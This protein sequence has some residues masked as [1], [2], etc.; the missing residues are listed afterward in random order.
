MMPGLSFI[1]DID[2]DLREKEAEILHSLNLLLHFDHYKA[3]I[4]LKD[5]SYFLCTTTYAE[6]PVSSFENDNYLIYLEG[7]IY[8][9]HYS[10]KKELN[11]LAELITENMTYKKEKIAEWLLNNDGDFVIFVLH[12]RSNEITITNDALGRLPLYYSVSDRN[13]LISREIR[14][15][16]HLLSN[17]DF[18]RMAI[19]QYLLFGYPLGKRTL[20]KNIYR[21]EPSSLI[22]INLNNSEIVITNIHQFCFDE[23]SYSTRTLK[24]NAHAL[25]DLFSDACKNRA[26]SFNDYKH[27]LSLSGGL[28]SRSVA[29]GLYRSNITF[30]GATYLDSNRNAIRDAELAKQIA[31]IF[32][33][34]WKLF[35]LSPPKGKDILKLLRMKSG[36][37]YLGMSFILPFLD[38]IKE[39]YGTQITYFTGDVGSVLRDLRPSRKIID[40]DELLKYILLNNQIYSPDDVSAMTRISKK[41]IIDELK[42]NIL[43]YPE[44]NWDQKYVH[45][46]I[47]EQCLKWCFEGEDRNRFYFWSVAPL[48]SISFFNFVMNCPDHLKSRH[49]LYR[50]FLLELYPQVCKINNADWNLPIISKR[51]P[52][53]LYLKSVFPLQYRKIIKQYLFMNSYP[54]ENR[55]NILNCIKEQLNNSQSI[56]DY[57][58]CAAV[59][60]IMKRSNKSQI[61]NLFTITSII[62]ELQYNQSTIE[63]YFEIEFV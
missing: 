16:T 28:D 49:A 1:Y 19:A 17:T 12:K 61:N 20:F 4:I 48:L 41:E 15:I 44:R 32:K 45:F 62:E 21:L 14:F 50:E 51:L 33:I 59:N 63:K 6:Y 35:E 23:K 8:N 5:K 46:L 18:D 36:L 52:I 57:L 42:K 43:T 29:A 37:N 3:N 11:T 24:E 60:N 2:K 27:I 47:Y 34:Y 26:N 30:Y 39:A 54:Y 40:I 31:N 7:K 53:K 38:S 55:S 56:S 10:V 13:L 25:V 22:K 58:S 9:H